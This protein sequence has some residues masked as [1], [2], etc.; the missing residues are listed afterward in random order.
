VI[1]R[2]NSVRR[3]SGKPDERH[4]APDAIHHDVAGAIPS[5]QEQ[6]TREKTHS[7]RRGGNGGHGVVRDVGA[8]G[9]M[10]GE[11]VS[12]V[13]S[14]SVRAGWGRAL[15]GPA[16]R[17]PSVLSRHSGR[18]RHPFG[19]PRT[20][21]EPTGQARLGPRA[22]A[23]P[24][25]NL[26]GSGRLRR[27]HSKRLTRSARSALVVC[28]VGQVLRASREIEINAAASL[29]RDQARPRSGNSSRSRNGEIRHG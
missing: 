13:P 23:R 9:D 15:R 17:D 7:G 19:T 18:Q 27:P 3:V 24:A 10:H 1:R 25:P 22:C 6:A 4:P 5:R 2:Q 12:P 20:R 14:V 16:L 11:G 8:H 28:P 26:S 21:H 29:P